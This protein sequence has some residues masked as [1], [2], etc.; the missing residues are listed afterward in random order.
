MKALARSFVWWTC[1]D[2]QIESVVRSC[3]RCQDVHCAPPATSPRPWT[4]PTKPWSRVHADCAGPID[5]KM[6]FVVVDAHS[7]WIEAVPTTSSTSWAT[8]SILR[9][10]FASHG[11]PDT[12]V[13]DD[14]PCFTSK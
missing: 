14:G 5:N 9:Q 10:L 11:V 2:G 4:W 7:K 12:L 3:E 6:V 1:L 8:I 13:T